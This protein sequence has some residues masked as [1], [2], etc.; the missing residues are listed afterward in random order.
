MIG[1]VADHLWQSTLVAALAAILALTL[2]RNRPQVRYALWLAASLKFLVPFAALVLVVNLSGWRPAAT[3]VRPDVTVIINVVS[4]PFSTMV[5]VPASRTRTGLTREQIT[6]IV[7]AGLWFCGFAAVVTTWMARWRRIAAAVREASLMHEGRELDTLRRLQSISGLT[8]PIALA[9]SNTPLEPGVFG[10]WRPVLLWPRSISERLE[11]RQ[12]EAILAHE[13]AHV[14]RRDNLAAAL[15]MAVQAL[16]WFY[17]LVWWV[18][19]RLVDERERAC[20]ADVVQL[21]SDPQVYAESILQTCQFYLESPLACVAGVTGSNLK[22]RIEEIMKNDAGHTL[23]AWRKLVLA[24]TAVAAVAAPVAI[25]TLNA[26]RA[27]S[28]SRA[29][30]VGTQSFASVSIKEN[31]SGERALSPDP[32][33]VGRFTVKNQPLRELIANL[34]FRDGRI[35]G[36]PEWLNDSFDIEAVAEGQPTAQEIRLM[37]RKLL[38]DRFKLAVHR[39]TRNLPVYALVLVKS[40]GTLGPRIRPSHPDCIADVEAR[41][42]GSKPFVPPPVPIGPT[43]PLDQWQLPCG[44]VA[45]RPSGRMAGRA[46]TMP[47]LAFGGFSGI[48]GR[49]VTDKTGLNGYFDFELE[50]EPAV[51]PGPPPN[52]LP[53]RLPPEWWYGRP[54]PFISSSF[55]TALQE[56]LGLDLASETGPVDLVVIDHVEKPT[57]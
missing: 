49:K 2:R 25:G 7:L 13:V 11:D 51:P 21:G 56:Q 6:S 27:Q 23:N 24:T 9:A 33:S 53:R 16:F 36:G 22:R 3:P 19:A 1:L 12:V 10:I 35:W 43:T 14:R 57:P 41:H 32:M 4:Q 45:S 48:V 38:A 44:S 29:L 47:E 37:V 5:T 31:T 17:P 55:F 26:A 40:D 52:P 20:D 8:R 28:Q 34:Y 30:E 39:E 18:G 15:H 42:N 50:F 54:A 46:T